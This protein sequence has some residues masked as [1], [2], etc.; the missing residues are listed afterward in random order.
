[1]SS[2]AVVLIGV[3]LAAAGSWGCSARTEGNAG[4][5]P[6]VAV[7][8]ATV[9]AADVEQAIEVVGSLAPKFAVDVKSEVT[10]TVAEVLV[11]EWV[12][13]RKGQVLARLDSREA[14]ATLAT[15]RAHLAQALAGEQAAVRE[16]ER[17]EKLKAYGLATAQNLD[18]ARTAREAA[19]AATEA[20][21]A[22]VRA[23]ETHL[24]KTAIVSP[25]DGVVAYRGVS[26]GD[27]VESM[28]GGPI[29]RLVDN[30]VLDLTVTVPSTRSAEVRV[31]QLLRFAVDAF[32]GRT[33]EGQVRFLNPAVDPASRTVSVTAEVRNEDGELRGGQFVKGRIVLGTRR[34]VLTVPR[35]A[36]VTQ[37]VAKG[38]GEL[39]VTDGQGVERRT[40][41]LGAGLDEAIEVVSG[42]AAGERV[43]TR[44][45][46]N[47]RPGDPIR[48]VT[49]EGA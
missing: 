37:D 14:E 6:A 44:G 1:M 11:T 48:I 46:F 40:V 5:R 15:A 8:V 23:A 49:P 33:F 13:V 26:A 41:Q 19:A 20:A 25:M 30:R 45:S 39:F 10:A 32:P 18:D 12:A 4:A 7:E 24:S 47:V 38:T 28:G 42:V 16:L 3:M 27:R 35:L 9:A 21:R 36:L 22:G 34:G 2:K 31:G 17:V 29:F 43:V